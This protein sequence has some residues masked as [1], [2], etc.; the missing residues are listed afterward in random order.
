MQSTHNKDISSFAI[1]IVTHNHAPHIS[2][3]I[4]SCRNV[5]HIPIYIC[6]A[7]STDDTYEQLQ[8]EINGNTSFHLT[9]KNRLE[10]FSKNNNDL[11]RKHSLQG[12]NIILINPDCY[13]E[14]SAFE[15]FI[16]QV[17]LVSEIGVAAPLLHY[18]DG[19][20]QVSWRK[21]PTLTA[22]LKNRF[23]KT[24]S[25][26]N[27][28]LNE[29]K[30][31]IFEIE[32]ALGAFLFISSKLTNTPP[33][34]ERY[35]LYCEDSDICMQAH[36]KN[37]RVVGIKT[38]GIHHALQERSTKSPLSKYNYWNF[39]SGI[40]FAIKWNRRYIQNISQK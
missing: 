30:S 33:L 21:F 40:K 32:W 18:P 11:I 20:I 24:E 17:G 2:K 9:R 6:D 35:R 3:L 1:L 36:A 19:S 4:S 29:I 7:A 15:N 39:S 14:K 22:F 27:H 8:R 26:N 31:N 25:I 28:Y 16:T 10:S 12:K 13:F 37:L 23:K 38:V 5:S 34:D